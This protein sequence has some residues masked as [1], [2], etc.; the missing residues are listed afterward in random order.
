MF[1]TLNQEVTSEEARNVT[2]VTHEVR[3][4]VATMIFV[5]CRHKFWW[6]GTIV[7]EDHAEISEDERM[8]NDR[9]DRIR[10]TTWRTF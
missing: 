9:G 2:C 4:A 3:M 10:Q 8:N 7:S 1:Q 6:S 5:F